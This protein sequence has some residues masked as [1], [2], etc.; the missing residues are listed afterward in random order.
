MDIETDTWRDKSMPIS[1]WSDSQRRWLE[2]GRY[3]AEWITE[4][5]KGLPL[6]VTGE[7]IRD[8]MLAGF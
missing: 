3:W 4:Y 8:L 5:G 2:A 7:T 1:V 6:S